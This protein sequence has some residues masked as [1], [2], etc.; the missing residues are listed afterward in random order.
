[1]GVNMGYHEG[2]N[3]FD[4]SNLMGGN[5]SMKIE[6]VGATTAR[7]A[8]TEK[9]LDSDL[10]D[11][12]IKIGAL[13]HAKE[14]GIINQLVFVGYPKE[15]HRD[16]KEYCDGVQSELFANLY[17][18]I[19]DDGQDGT[20]YNDENYYAAY[21]Y[22]TV[23]IYK[24]YVKVWE[25]WNEPDLT[26]SRS[27]YAKNEESGSWWSENPNPCDLAIKAPIT[28]YVRMLRISWEVIKTID[29]EAYVAIGGIGYPS[30]LDAIL[31][32]TDEPERGT[33][34]GNFPLKGGA[35]FD[36]ASYHTYPHMDN[37]IRKW[38]NK[39]GDFTFT[40]TS[41]AAVKGV[42][43]RKQELN[44]VLVKHG[45]DG[46]QY[47]KKE[48]IIS[49]FNVP[50]KPLQYDF[51]SDELQRNFLVKMFV[52]AQ[53]QGI[54]QIHVYNLADI[55]P[56]SKAIKPYDEIAVMGL[57][58]HI[59]GNDQYPPKLT[60][61]GKAFQFINKAM[62]AYTFDSVTTQKITE[63]EGVNGGVFKNQYG[64]R[65]F[66]LWAE[67]PEGQDLSEKASKT[68]DLSKIIYS[69]RLVAQPLSQF[70]NIGK[71]LRAAANNEVQLSG[72]PML[73]M[74]DER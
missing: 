67:T 57:Y 59:V 21:L 12:D 23:S 63:L 40:R 65:A 16:K 43:T 54:R 22:K 73:I 14:R 2:R 30:F 46:K 66:V 70:E 69:K 51:G 27:A 47:P 10:W 36:V 3:D 33:V 32:N 8:L 62:K 31:R 64:K 6:G 29:P 41:D 35:Y 9:V 25:I 44:D 55:V 45:Y 19:W 17:E 60:E 72:E 13:E 58:E 42:F 28:H 48:W 56:A 53:K 15:A 20:P 50:R 1:M 39:K 26:K 11:Y 7:Q 49:E 37:S 52:E 71:S 38:D 4:L 24:D 61:L 74:V 34:T 5:D 18:D 68:V